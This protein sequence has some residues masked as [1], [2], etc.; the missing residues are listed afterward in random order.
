MIAQVASASLVSENKILCHPASVD[1][2]PSSAGK[3]DH[4][5]M[6]SVSARKLLQVVTNVKHSLAIEIMTAA[7]G[8]DQ[9]KPL[10]PSKGVTAAQDTVRAKVAPMTEDR[11]LY[12]D[13]EAVAVM[14]ADGALVKAV[15]KRHRPTRVT[16]LSARVGSELL[17]AVRAHPE[18]RG[19]LSEIARE[20]PGV[21]AELHA[22]INEPPRL[23]RKTGCLAVQSGRLAR[24]AEG[25]WRKTAG[26]SCESRWLICKT[27][28]LHF[29][30]RRLTD[31]TGSPIRK[32]R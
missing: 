13:I 28:R 7:A 11:P 23:A 25:L 16:R 1:S 22:V 26:L 14:I 10:R 12:Q 3:E 29:K 24:E 17:E 18:V 20:R 5:S 21:I 2:I 4:V 31:Q 30:P 15:E 8:I 6:G 19:E 27:G 9:R 32:P